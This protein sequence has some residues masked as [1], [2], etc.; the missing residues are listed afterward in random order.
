MKGI[1]ILFLSIAFLAKG[2]SS[3]PTGE[4]VP[5]EW[6]LDKAIKWTFQHNIE[7]LQSIETVNRFS[8]QRMIGGSAR[9]PQLSL[10]AS[11]DANSANLIDISEN[12][13]A[14]IIDPETRQATE[15]YGASFEIRQSLFFT[16]Y[17]NRKLHQADKFNELAAQAKH[18][19]T[20]HRVIA[21]LTQSFDSVLFS[22]ENVSIREASVST[23]KRLL[24]VATKRYQAGDIPEL[25][26]LRLKSELNRAQADLARAENQESAS[27]ERLKRLL[28][29]NDTSHS[30]KLLGKLELKRSTSDF[31]SLTEQ[32]IE[33]RMDLKASKMEWEAAQKKVKAAKTSKYPQLEAVAGYDVRSSFY[34]VDRDVDGWRVALV[35]SVDLFAIGKNKGSRLMSESEANLA[36]LGYENLKLQIE[37]S[38]REFQAQLN[39]NEQI[40]ESRQSALEFAGK[41]LEQ[42][43]AQYE[44]G[45]AGL[46]IVLDAQDRLNKARFEVAQSILSHN[47]T[48]AQLEY[49]TASS[50]KYSLLQGESTDK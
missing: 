37:S 49:S 14:G 24:D 44:A 18:L 27:E 41:A 9:L 48:V 40:I 28:A 39:Q 1:A 35:A 8:G 33:N 13:T 43:E 16:Q 34:D 42:I 15:G 17:R 26:I 29:I 19:D 46:E 45:A 2:H 31:D 11:A 30:L 10:S 23:F 12:D 32:A 21:I 20:T 22:E 6:T 3:T 7:I 38:I 4:S 25:E 5:E 47:A 50:P 36:R